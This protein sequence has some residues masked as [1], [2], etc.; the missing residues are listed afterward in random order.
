MVSETDTKSVG[1]TLKWGG[2]A[3]FLGRYLDQ[4]EAI[5]KVYHCRDTLDFI[6]IGYCP[7]KTEY[8]SLDLM[9]PDQDQNSLLY[10]QNRRVSTILRLGQQTNQW[11]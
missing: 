10:K 6:A 5:V 2:K 8:D 9:K 4:V 11:Q 3:K 1:N 7:T